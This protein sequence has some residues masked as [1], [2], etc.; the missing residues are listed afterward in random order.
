MCIVIIVQ[1]NK[2]ML[3]NILWLLVFLFSIALKAARLKYKCNRS[4]CAPGAHENSWYC[5]TAVAIDGHPMD[6]CIFRI[7]QVY[8]YRMLQSLWVRQI[9][10]FCCILTF[11]LIELWK[12][13]ELNNTVRQKANWEQPGTSVKLNK[14]PCIQWTTHGCII[15]TTP[16]TER[17]HNYRLDF[18]AH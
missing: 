6:F 3:F 16:C 15:R 14:H 13:P 7:T 10:L 2:A 1:I 18:T 5:K 12:V 8:R 4:L 17:F 9:H 11:N